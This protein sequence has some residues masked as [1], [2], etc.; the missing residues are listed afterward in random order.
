[1]APRATRVFDS[2]LLGPVHVTLSGRRAPGRPDG[3]TDGD[4]LD[5]SDADA[6]RP[7]RRTRVVDTALM[8]PVRVTPS[9]RR[10]GS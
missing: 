1:M 4:G 9:G 8:G 3:V 6:T 10:V 2:G 5:R 7:L